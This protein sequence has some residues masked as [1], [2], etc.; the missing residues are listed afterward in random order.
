M[1]AGDMLRFAAH[2]ID[3]MLP[4]IKDPSDPLWQCWVVHVKYVRLL[5]QHSLTYAEI[6][7]LDHIDI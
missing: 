3:L 5:L 1:T 6:L 4:L 2:S 7:E